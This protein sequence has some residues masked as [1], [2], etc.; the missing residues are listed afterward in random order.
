MKK[1]LLL[2]SL[3]C[4]PLALSAQWYGDGLSP[5][6]A[7]YGVINTANPMQEWNITNYP[8][9][10]IYVGQSTTGWEDLSVGNGGTLTIQQ[11][12]TVKFCTTLS[13]LRITGTGILNAQ[14]SL[15][16]L[17]T[18]TKN[19]QANWGHISFESMTTINPENYPSVLSNCVIEWGNVSSASLLPA[20]PNQYGGAIHIDFSYVSISDCELRNN[21]AGWGGSIFVGDG[22][23]PS[24]SKCYIHDNTATTSGGGLYFWKNSSPVITNSIVTY[25]NCTGTGGG[26]G[27][28]I[29]GAA[30]GVKVINCTISHNTANNQSLG[31]NIKIFNNTATPKPQFI[32]SIIWYPA[33]S[34]VG[35]TYSADF[36]NCAIQ[37]PPLTTYTGYIS[38]N[39]ANEGTNPSGPFFASMSGSSWPL[40]FRSPCRDAGTT[41][42]PAV[43]NDYVGNPRVY[44]YDMGAYEYQYARWK[45]TAGSTDWNTAD[46]WYGGIPTST[47]D[48]LIPAGAPNYPTTSPG[49]DFTIGSGKQMIIEPGARVTLANLTNNGLINLI[50][51]LQ[52]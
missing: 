10:I 47:L 7:Y 11:G 43:T 31:Y 14:G 41:P 36:L 9:G 40:Q 37:D 33:N 3:T 18:F 26:G 29:G 42:T 16:N 21:K 6:T 22:K 35:S 27:I 39:S 15:S 5:A 13:D 45:T 44:N 25:N 24:I 46:N 2:I 20:N 50:I 32:N 17:I 23:S 38:L 28:F 52:D 34:I 48:V 49:A 8:G 30:K 51:T 4:V 1:A 12:I 19:A